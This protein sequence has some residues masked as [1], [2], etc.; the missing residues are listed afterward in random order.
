MRQETG[1]S[2]NGAGRGSET[3]IAT[4][5]PPLET[6]AQTGTV[7]AQ[8]T[9]PARRSTWLT[10][11]PQDPAS[12]TLGARVWVSQGRSAFNFG[13]SGFADVASELMWRGQNTRIY[14]VKADLVVRRFVATAVLGW[15]SI[16]EGTLRD[17]DFM[18]NSRT[19][20]FSDT[21]SPTT[22]GS[23]IYGSFDFGPRFVRWTYKGNPGAVDVVVGFQFWREKYTARGLIDII[24]GGTNLSANA[25]TETITWKSVRLGP[26]VTVPVHSRVTLVGQALYLPWTRYDNEDIHHLRGDLAQ[27]PSG[28]LHASGGEGIQLEGGLQL[29]VWKALKLE[30]GYRYWD[31]RSGSGTKETFT[32][33]V[34]PDGSIG[35]CATPSEHLNGAKAR[36]EGPYFGLSWTF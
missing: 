13:V 6:T 28:E 22:D 32:F 17:Q 9:Q 36:R 14:E 20:I 16:D 27:D 31:L 3:N 5:R 15:G 8:K 29:A 24:P 12:L 2:N 7:S 10:N 1:N 26:R 11:I 18:G 21:L 34:F 33:C 23:V 35:T 4:E 19:Q 25:I 30:A